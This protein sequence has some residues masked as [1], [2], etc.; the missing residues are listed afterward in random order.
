MH[1]S[2]VIVQH[3]KTEQ[4]PEDEEILSSDPKHIVRSTAGIVQEK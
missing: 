3:H 1:I 2:S 4:T